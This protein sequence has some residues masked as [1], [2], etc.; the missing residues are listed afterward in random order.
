VMIKL[1]TSKSERAIMAGEITLLRHA[2]AK[3]TRLKIIH[4]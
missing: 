4:D 3:R 1:V 2:Q